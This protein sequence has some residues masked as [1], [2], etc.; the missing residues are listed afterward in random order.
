[1]QIPCSRTKYF[2]SI[3]PEHLNVVFMC[4]ADDEVAGGKR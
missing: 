3:P 4:N 2:H 1:M